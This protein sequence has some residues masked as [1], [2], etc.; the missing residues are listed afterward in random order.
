MLPELKRQKRS[1]IQGKFGASK[2]EKNSSPFLRENQTLSIIFLLLKNDI[3]IANSPTLV[4]AVL[5]KMNSRILFFYEE[6]LLKL[7]FTNLLQL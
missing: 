1:T 7:F 6:I 2:L 3:E 4:I 5:D